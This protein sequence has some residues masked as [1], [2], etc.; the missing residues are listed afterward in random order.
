MNLSYLQWCKS[1]VILDASD[2][3]DEKHLAIICN[4]GF[5]YYLKR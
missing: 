3:K 1:Y 4:K 5:D 2:E